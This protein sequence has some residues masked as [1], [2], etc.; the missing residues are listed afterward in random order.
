[1]DYAYPYALLRREVA[2][3]NPGAEKIKGYSEDEILGGLFS[4][5]YTPDEEAAGGPSGA[6]CT[7]VGKPADSP[8]RPGD[9]VNMGSCF[10]AL[11]VI[12]PVSS[13]RHINRLCQDHP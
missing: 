9:A 4:R 2:S 5:F 12:A 6:L 11:V 10:W 13:G 1:M 3:W 7:A 8:Q